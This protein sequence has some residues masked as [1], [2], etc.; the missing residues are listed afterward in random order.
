MHF[1]LIDL[2][3][4]LHILDA[5]NITAGASRSHLSLA[6]ASARIRA[7]EAALGVE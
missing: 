4:Y 3:L 7:M 5:G 1:D 2:R 6:A